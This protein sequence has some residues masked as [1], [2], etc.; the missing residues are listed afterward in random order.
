MRRFFNTSDRAETYVSN[1]CLQASDLALLLLDDT[2]PDVSGLL[3]NKVTVTIIDFFLG[4]ALAV[5]HHGLVFSAV[6]LPEGCELVLAVQRA[7]GE[8]QAV[9][10]QV[11]AV[12]AALGLFLAMTHGFDMV[13][14]FFV[15]E[16]GLIEP[17]LVQV[18]VSGREKRS[19]ITCFH[20]DLIHCFLL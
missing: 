2:R 3:G 11:L 12:G 20:I 16:D 5:A 4:A 6:E 14:V 8:V 9:E 17:T 19:G 10:E 7:L 13:E 1:Q 18:G 15:G